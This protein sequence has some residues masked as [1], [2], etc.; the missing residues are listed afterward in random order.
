MPTQDKL[1][2]LEDKVILIVSSL[3]L[4]AVTAAVFWV[5]RQ[6]PDW[7]A[8]R[9]PL[10]GDDGD[11]EGLRGRT[12]VVAGGRE[13]LKAARKMAK[14]RAKAEFRESSAGQKR[15][16]RVHQHEVRHKRTIYCCRCIPYDRVPG[17]TC[18]HRVRK[19]LLY[20]K[21]CDV[22]LGHDYLLCSSRCD[23]VTGTTRYLL[24]S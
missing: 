3:G 2:F 5:V 17:T 9:L 18:H 22:G 15:R 21:M 12:R 4:L 23:L 7:G 14:K 13:A 8:N 19:C 11:E 10:E 6:S 1:T 20:K 24:R 16:S